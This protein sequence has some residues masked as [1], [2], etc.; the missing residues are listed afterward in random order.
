MVIPNLTQIM[1]INK[2]NSLEGGYGGHCVDIGF[3]MK[4]KRLTPK[5]Q[6]RF[7]RAK[8]SKE[9]A[10]KRALASG[11]PLPK[12]KSKPVVDKFDMYVKVKCTEEFRPYFKRPYKV[13]ASKEFLVGKDGCPEF[14]AVKNIAFCTGCHS[15]DHTVGDCPYLRTDLREYLKY[16]A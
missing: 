3:T 6:V 10:E 2:I 5:W 9:E 11:K 8:A 4:G 14:F 16:K 15:E 13:A 12:D 1:P 7:D